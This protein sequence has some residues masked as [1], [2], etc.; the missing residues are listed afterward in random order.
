[1]KICNAEVGDSIFM[2]CGKINEVER[3]LS[4]SRDKIANDLKLIKNDQFNFLF[5]GWLTKECIIR[6]STLITL[7]A[8]SN[9]IKNTNYKK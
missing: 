4:I 5:I 3:I 8:L 9:L 7:R 2:A 6:K 1:M